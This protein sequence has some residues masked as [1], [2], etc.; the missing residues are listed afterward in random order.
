MRRWTVPRLRWRVGMEGCDVGLSLAYA[1][2]LGWRNATLDC[3][4]LTPRVGMEECEA[5]W[6]SSSLTLAPD[7]GGL[8]DH[9]V[10]A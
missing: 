1:G 9:A 10:H 5:A 2:G 7:T 3:P 8:A 6:L 4:S